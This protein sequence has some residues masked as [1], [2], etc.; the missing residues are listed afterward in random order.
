MPTVEQAVALGLTAAE[1]ELICE[2]IG[3]VPNEVELAVFSLMWSGH[4]AY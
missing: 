3:R 1:Y 4:C 2:Q